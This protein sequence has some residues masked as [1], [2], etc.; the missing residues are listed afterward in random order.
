[1]RIRTLRKRNKLLQ[2]ELGDACGV[3]RISVRKWERG[4]SLPTTDK[5]PI[6]AATLGVEI[7]ELFGEE[8]PEDLAEEA[9]E[10]DRA[11]G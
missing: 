8:D 11:A 10:E 9:L 2:R 6:L 7:G 3:S 1:M 4:T 5:L